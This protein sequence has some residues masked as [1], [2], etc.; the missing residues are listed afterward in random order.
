MADDDEDDA[1]TA[2]GEAGDEGLNSTGAVRR[3]SMSQLPGS[4][5]EQG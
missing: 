1:T 2:V 3:M 5:A 4:D